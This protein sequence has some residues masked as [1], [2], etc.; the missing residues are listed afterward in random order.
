MLV[1]AGIV[2]IQVSGANAQF[3]NFGNLIKK[4]NKQT[5]PTNQ[6]Q[7]AQ[8]E[9]TTNTAGDNSANDAGTINNSQN[10]AASNASASALNL[11]PIFEAARQGD[12]VKFAELLKTNIS[13]VNKTLDQ[14]SG[15]RFYNDFDHPKIDSG[16]HIIPDPAEKFKDYTLLDFAAENGCTNIVQQLLDV[17]VDFEAPRRIITSDLAAAN[18]HMNFVKISLENSQI[19]KVLK[20]TLKALI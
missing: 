17:G 12:G 15:L 4:L 20:S 6:P 13:S 2:L 18:G 10:A 16:G 3:G 9:T 11:P 19:I 5:A 7:I 8:P 14:A 1:V